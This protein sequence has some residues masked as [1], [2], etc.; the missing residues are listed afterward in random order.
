L[1]CLFIPIEAYYLSKTGQWLLRYQ[2]NEITLFQFV[3]GLTI[4]NQLGE[5]L[6]F[7][8]SLQNLKFSRLVANN[9]EQKASYSQTRFWLNSLSVLDTVSVEF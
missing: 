2:K 9:L 5:S 8:G 6:I 4:K 1:L 3:K 7:L